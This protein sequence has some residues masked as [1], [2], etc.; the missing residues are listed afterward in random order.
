M[1]RRELATPDCTFGKLSRSAWNA[2]KGKWAVAIGAFA[3]AAVIKGAAQQIPIAGPLFAGYFLVPLDAGVMFFCL[4]LIRGEKTPI[5]SIFDL[6]SDYWR[7]VWGG[8]RVALFVFLRALP[9]IADGILLGLCCLGYDGSDADT[10]WLAL[11]I[12]ALIVLLPVLTIPP[13]IAG[14]RYGMTIYIMIDRPEY[15]AKDAMDE[16]AAIM[17]GRKGQYFGYGLLIG[18]IAIPVTVFT[19]GIGLF[20]F[21]PWAGVFTALFYESILG[22]ET[23]PEVPEIAGDTA[24]A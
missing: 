2:L 18:L 1:D 17:Y 15:S 12:L 20:W 8:V 14:L 7:Y 4:K 3:L 9:L 11:P 6:F 19:L 13:V 5:E 21:I 22:H 10:G 23:I 24:E 16:S